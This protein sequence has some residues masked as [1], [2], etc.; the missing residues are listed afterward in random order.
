ML[1]DFL[2]PKQ[3]SQLISKH[4]RNGTLNAGPIK[5]VNR[6][7][8]VLLGAYIIM[9]P[10]FISDGYIKFTIIAWFLFPFFVRFDSR[11]MFTKHI[12]PYVLGKKISAEVYKMHFYYQGRQRVIC[13]D[14][15]NN[16]I[17]AEMYGYRG[18]TRLNKEDYPKAG[19]TVAIFVHK[20]SSGKYWGMLDID[21]IKQTFSLTTEIL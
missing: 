15:D 6:H 11:R 18:K 5:E 13:F 20:D 19:D 17:I 4:E 3:M 21:Y 2:Y 8:Y 1:K 16:K 14:E 7:I 9:T 12:A 10:L